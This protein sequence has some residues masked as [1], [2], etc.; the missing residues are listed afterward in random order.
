M[1]SNL[2][3]RDF[4]KLSVAA[5]GG[6]AAGVSSESLFAQVK[7]EEADTKKKKEIHVCRGLN[8]CKGNG[9]DGKNACAG[10]GICATAEAHDCGGQN[11]CK[12]QGG[13]GAMPGENDCKT[14]GECAVP[15][16]DKAW[17]T[18]RKRFEDRMKKAKKKYGEAP[19]KKEK[20]K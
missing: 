14:K 1:P 17:T 19:K 2:N 18:A 11:V 5:L 3:R 7:K 13:C 20:A 10:Q 4:G 6:L 9:T 16:M 8:T 15:L 12:G